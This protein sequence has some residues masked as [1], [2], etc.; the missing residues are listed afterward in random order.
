MSTTIMGQ[1]YNPIRRTIKN[2]D[3]FIVTDEGGNILENNPSGFGLYA[4]DTRYLSKFELKINKS[5]SIVLSSSTETGYSSVI[6]ATNSNIRDY[7]DESVLIPQESVEIKRESIIYGAYYETITITN[8]NL[9]KVGMRLDLSFGSDFL[10]IFEVRS[11]SELVKGHRV[12]PVYTDNSIKFTYID[13]T[14]ATLSTEIIFDNIPSRI[15]KD[16]A[17]FEF[18]LLPSEKL[19][20]R[21]QI[22]IK[23][24]AALSF[25]NRATCIE[26]AFEQAQKQESELCKTVTQFTCD[27][28][29]YNDLLQ[30]S[31]KDMNM[32]TTK[33]HFGTYIAAGIPWFT[34][35]FGRDCLIAGRQALMLSPEFAK[36]ILY[37]LAKFQGK[38]NNPWKDEEPGKI[39]HEIR[40]GELA[41]SNIVPHS[42]YYG[43]VDST[44]LWLILY[45]EY[46]KW[47]NDAQTLSDLWPN[48][49]ACLDWIENN[50]KFNGYATYK[51]RSAKGLTNQSWKDSHNSNIHSDGSLAEAPITAVEAQGYTYSAKIKMAELCEYFNDIDKKASLTSSAEELKKRFHKDFWIEDLQYYALGLDKS[52]NRMEVVSSNPGQCLETG[53]IDEHYANIVADRLFQP[54]MFSGWGIRTLSRQC[55]AYNPMSYHNGSVW[56]HDNSII[57]YGLS[58]INRPDLVHKSATAL[59]EAAR[60]MKYKRLPELFCGFSRMY[61]QDPP[62]MYP[63]TCTP[64]AWAAASIYFLVQSMLNITP[65]AQKNELKIVT[66]SLSPWMHFLRI[67]NLHV[68]KSTVDMEFQRTSKGLV[69]DILD[70]KGD[71]DIIIKY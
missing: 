62:V 27:N 48:A 7:F 34:T 41:R 23:S 26:D 64:Q 68:G 4:Y 19:T 5:D 37:T 2:N 25:Q 6:I 67:E 52:N 31:F 29:D 50:L 22:N 47:T 45:Y 33:A 13:S 58:K 57:I 63:L 61:K 38:E 10:D 32:L 54:D 15:V 51:R 39:P 14:G 24:T 56:P 8:Y 71:V 20:F 1:N 35:L 66:P 44:S 30:I 16:A 43:S 53:I 11:I 69:L 36:N 3:I 28:E 21:Y 42:S 49:L 9:I 70:K 17:V 40:F 60:Q 65:D 12:D 18:E 55:L 59:F 46:Y